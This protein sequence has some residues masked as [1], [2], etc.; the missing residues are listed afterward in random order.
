VIRA[1][2]PRWPHRRAEPGH[3]V[4]RRPRLWFA[5]GLGLASIAAVVT[6]FF[7][8]SSR[9]PGGPTLPRTFGQYGQCY[10]VRSPS[11][12]TEL[13]RA[14]DCPT[15]STAARMPPAW[16]ISYFPFYNS[17]YYTATFVRSHDRSSYRAFMDS[18]D[19]RYS[20]KIGRDAPFATY[21]DSKGDEINGRSAG[22]NSS[23]TGISTDDS[24]RWLRRAPSQRR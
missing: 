21:I 12:A 19:A 14:G 22:V 24:T 16:L 2:F 20:D 13:K 3:Q 18:F 5:Y 1:R 10:Y 4:R 6:V 7:V 8:V 9:S 11:E 17:R 23:D 15:F